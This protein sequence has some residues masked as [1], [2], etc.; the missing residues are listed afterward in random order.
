MPQCLFS[1]TSIFFTD[2]Q[3]FVD[4]YGFVT[5][6]AENVVNCVLLIAHRVEFRLFDLREELQQT[7]GQ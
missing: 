6:S 5:A 4:I 7:Q 2:Y 3:R 1:T